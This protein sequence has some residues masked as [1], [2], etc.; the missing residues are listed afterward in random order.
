MLKKIIENDKDNG[1]NETEKL[2][3]EFLIQR[4]IQ[5]N[6]NVINVFQYF[7]KLKIS[8][9]GFHTQHFSYWMHQFFAVIFTYLYEENKLWNS[10]KC[11]MQI[12]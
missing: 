9:L 5:N 4:I 8:Y 7:Q 6:W 1:S 3:V 11:H 12:E 2:H 10:D